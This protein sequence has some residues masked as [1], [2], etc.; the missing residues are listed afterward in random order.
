MSLLIAGIILFL[1]T[2]MIRVVAPD[3]RNVMIAKLG[4]SGWK[5]LY[6]CPAA[7]T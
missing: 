2:H 6:G 7:E 3:F 1:G 4:E 5:G